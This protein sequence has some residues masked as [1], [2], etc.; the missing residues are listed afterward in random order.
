MVEK[1]KLKTS[2]RFMCDNISTTHY[3]TIVFL[4]RALA[5]MKDQSAPFL[6]PGLN[7]TLSQQAWI[8][9]TQFFCGG[10]E[11]SEKHEKYVLEKWRHETSGHTTH[12]FR[13]L[14]PFSDSEQFS[15]D[16]DCPMDSPMNPSSRCALYGKIP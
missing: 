2:F 12:A 11:F 4:P 5:Q 16:W 15:K 8:A 10:T 1:L 7:F 14:G 13:V 6:L 3:F 9:K